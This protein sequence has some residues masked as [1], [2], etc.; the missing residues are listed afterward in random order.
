MFLK[1]P[2]KSCFYCLPSCPSVKS[3]SDLKVVLYLVHVATPIIASGPLDVILI[4]DQAFAI[5]IRCKAL[6]SPQ[7]LLGPRHAR[8]QPQESR[9]HALV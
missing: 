1:A 6:A 7:F 9:V 2:C 4:Q 3:L 5:V 8:P